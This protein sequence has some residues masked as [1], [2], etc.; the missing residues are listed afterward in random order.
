[1]VLVL[2]FCTILIIIMLLIVSILISAIKIN[3]KNFEIS[4]IAN[5]NMNKDKYE[6][7]ISLNLFNKLKWIY[8]KLDQEKIHRIT[9]KMHLDKI[10][11]QKLEKDFKI[12]DLKQ[13]CKIRP[14]LKSL[15]LNLKFGFEDIMFTTYLI[16]IISILISN[17][18][19]FVT[20]KEDIK[21]IKYNLEPI[22]SK[23]YNQKNLYYLKVSSSI[24][25]KMLNLLNSVFRIY[26]RRKKDKLNLNKN[27][28]KKE[29]KKANEN[30]LVNVQKNKKNNINNI[31]CNV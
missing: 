5:I 2:I 15:D 30:K 8:I 29:C 19:P 11:I 16:P 14:V 24:E 12:S 13:I 20:K 22:Y 28:N 7:E 25:I 26:K 9:L 17:I 6:I 1:M 31:K 27:K 4:N 3:I 18:L 23:I 21:N 10:D